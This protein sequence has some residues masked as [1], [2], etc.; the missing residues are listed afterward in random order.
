MIFNNFEDYINDI[1]NDDDRNTLY[2]INKNPSVE[3]LEK[4][5][6]GGSYAVALNKLKLV[7]TKLNNYRENQNTN[8]QHQKRGN[9][10]KTPTQIENNNRSHK[11][12][13]QTLNKSKHEPTIIKRQINQNLTNKT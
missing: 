2:G 3:Q 6:K 5:Y 9:N 11:S 12:K 4:A 8:E 10:V 7:K 1:N 13:Q